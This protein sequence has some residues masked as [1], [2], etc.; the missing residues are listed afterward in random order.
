MF[1]TDN[2]DTKNIMQFDSSFAQNG[3]T[4]ADLRSFSDFAW[5][6]VT[7]TAP[8][9]YVVSYLCSVA[10]SSNYYFSVWTICVGRC[11]RLRLTCWLFSL[12][13]SSLL[14][15]QSHMLWGAV[16]ILF[17]LI[18]FS[19]YEL[20]IFLVVFAL[21]RRLNVSLWFFVHIFASALFCRRTNSRTVAY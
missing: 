9:M 3:L 16:F 2:V 10:V 14:R 18:L 4:H 13:C 15:V 12:K 6:L 1:K 21:F 17:F 7:F 5:D 19:H 20:V 8:Q 11:Y